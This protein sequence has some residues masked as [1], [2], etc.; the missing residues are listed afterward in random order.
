MTDLEPENALRIYFARMKIEESFRDLKSLLGMT[1]LMNKQQAYMEKMLALLFLVYSIGLLLGEH[2]RDYLFAEHIPE[3]EPVPVEDRLPGS[4]NCKKG[5]K[6]KK[7]SGLFVLLKK[8]YSLS[9]SSHTLI[10]NQAFD[11]FVALVL[12]SVRTHV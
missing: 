5:K 11:S 3:N 6:W 2:L 7:Y 4:P 8:K 1:R 9:S 10:F 12:P